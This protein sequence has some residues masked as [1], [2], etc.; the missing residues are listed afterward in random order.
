EIRQMKRGVF[1]AKPQMKRP[2]GIGKDQL[3]ADLAPLIDALSK[4]EAYPFPV[5]EVEVHQTHISVVF[6]AGPHAH[7]LHKPV[8]VG[9][10]DFSTLAKRREFCE[11]EVR[12][13]RR[14][15]PEVYLGVVPV[16]A[17]QAGFRVEEAG[18]AA[19]WAVKMERLPEEATLLQRLKRGEVGTA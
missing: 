16:V 4:P 14:L 1:G 5:E 10:L 19:E 12:L 3:V 6:L 17:H 11:Q 13:N 18:E 8:N 7:K 2:D 9:F 15:A